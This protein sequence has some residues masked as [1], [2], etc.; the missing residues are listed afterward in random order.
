MAGLHAK[1]NTTFPKRDPW[2]QTS[3][4]HT[5]V[6]DMSISIEKII[7]ALPQGALPSSSYQEYSPSGMS[8]QLT[9]PATVTAPIPNQ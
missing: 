8:L 2:P 7:I 5:Y 6:C 4:K 9:F 3:C 1:R